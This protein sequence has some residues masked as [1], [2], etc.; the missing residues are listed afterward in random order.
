MKVSLI[1][2]T[3]NR[4]KALTLVMQSA[5]R[6]T[7]LP[8]E[9]IIAD[10]GSTNETRDAVLEFADSVSIP[11]VHSWHEDDGFRLSESRNR[12]IAS[13]RYDYIILVD[14]DMVL[15]KNYIEDHCNAAK[16]GVMYVNSR[17]FL[18]EYITN[19]M[20]LRQSLPKIRL[21]SKYIDKSR[22]NNIRIPYLWKLLPEIK[23]YNKAKGYMGFWRKDCIAING[24]DQ[25]Y[26]GWGREDSDFLLRMMNNNIKA[27]KLKY[28]ALAYHL[29]HNEAN[30]D[31]FNK[32]HEMMEKVIRDKTI[33][34]KNGL[35]KLGMSI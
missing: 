27:R 17:T 23:S 7:R 1:I 21:F 9:I 2:T 29:W 6:Q 24:F 34:C 26:K 31:N 14:G 16:E 13:A 5:I 20:E 12:A 22:F 3:Y 25:D 8:D 19:Q 33:R 30:R 15:D 32:N 11:V 10:D 4:P 35:D 18:N 28:S